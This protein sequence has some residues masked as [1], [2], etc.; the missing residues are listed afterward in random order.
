MKMRDWSRER[1]RERERKEWARDKQTAPG[2]AFS[3][4]RQR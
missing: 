1:D 4:S 2:A 3:D